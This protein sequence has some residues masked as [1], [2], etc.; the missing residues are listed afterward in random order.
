MVIV[1]GSYDLQLNI[2]G[3]TVCKAIADNGVLSMIYDNNL[4]QNIVNSLF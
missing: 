2:L 1:Y 4:I 3:Q